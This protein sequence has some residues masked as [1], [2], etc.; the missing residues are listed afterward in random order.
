MAKANLP[1][2]V[3]RGL[4]GELRE[5]RRAR[6]LA[7]RR[8]AA[9]LEWQASKLSR[10][11][12][13]VQGI[14][15]AD[16]ASLL[17]IYGVTGEER[18][19]LLAMAERSAETGWWEAIGGLSDESRTLI[20]L[21]AEAAGIVNWEPLLV[22]GLLQ[23]PDYAQAVMVGCGVPSDEAQGRVAA[24]LGR[25]AI[26][27]RPAPPALHVLLDE[28]V[29]RRALGGPRVMA[30]QLRHLLEAAERPTV[31]LRVVPLAVGAHTGLDGSF[32]LLD[33]PRNRSVVCLDHKLTGLFLEEA[34]QVAHFR[35][36][37]DRLTAAALS[38]VDSMALVA[39]YVA[40]HERE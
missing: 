37:A 34:A 36:E 18:R 40:E 8:V 22:P 21:E 10:M 11:E 30:R 19:R 17:V 25:Q 27:S 31:T 20:R 23:T 13:G 32:A 38:P 9:R 1:T 16:V 14:Q 33:F 35:R 2:V 5:L 15:A 4:G 39:R 24:R 12:T 6:G 3:G 28:A 26:L 7:L 29:L